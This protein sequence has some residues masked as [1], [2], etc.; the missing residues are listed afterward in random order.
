V[1]PS[2]ALLCALGV[3]AGAVS[4][5][6]LIPGALN[7]A[8]AGDARIETFVVHDSNA[9]LVDLRARREEI[10]TAGVSRLRATLS[11]AADCSSAGRPPPPIGRVRL[12]H[13]YLNLQYG[14]VDPRYAD[15][16]RPYA[17]MWTTA[18][19]AASRYAA[20][21]E[22]ADARCV[23]DV[24]EDWAK[25][26]ALLDYSAKESRQAW[27]V[28]EWAASAAGLALSVA[29]AEPSVPAEQRI[30]VLAWL[31]RVVRKQISEP[32]GPISC[33]NN[34]AHWRGLMAMAAGVVTRD[35][36]LFRY[37][38]MRFRD[39]LDGIAADGSFPLEMDRHERALH[40]QNYALLPLVGIAELASRQGYD[41]YKEHG[42]ASRSIHDAVRFLLAALDDQ[43]LVR[44]YASEPQYLGAFRPG[45]GDLAWM[46]AYR[47]R[48]PSPRFERFLTS[49]P[50]QPLLGGETLVYWHPLP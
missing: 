42:R 12:P 6:D 43:S 50:F 15:A 32:S 45:T 27:F 18:T 34:H 14:P 47:R 4:S 28:V 5:V 9:S 48:F 13:Y 41:L 26:D 3:V 23:F 20:F 49:A 29:R 33:C 40:Y 8:T 36:E 39:A 25:V 24:L 46:E 44:R 11:P 16:E 7:P 38:V 22:P 10:G 17:S 35:D 30:R 31:T 21:A 19:R 1:R 2:R 37:G